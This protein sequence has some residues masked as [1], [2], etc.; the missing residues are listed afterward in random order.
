MSIERVA[1]YAKRL[2]D[3]ALQLDGFEALAILVCIRSI[4]TVRV[5]AISS[6]SSSSSSTPRVE[7]MRELSAC[8]SQEH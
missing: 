7:V 5:K 3:V 8:R 4:M 2:M 1:A 6:S